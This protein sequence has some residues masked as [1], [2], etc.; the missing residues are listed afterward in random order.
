MRAPF[1]VFIGD[2]HNRLDLLKRALAMVP[3][4]ALLAF[5]GDLVDMRHPRLARASIVD[6]QDVL[7]VH[8]ALIE[9]LNSIDTS[10]FFVLGNHD[11]LALTERLGSQWICLDLAMQELPGTDF[12]LGGIG[13]SHMIPPG[14]PKDTVRRFIEG[15]IPGAP[16]GAYK[17]RG[18]VEYPVNV[19]GEPCT[20]LSRIPGE[21]STYKGNPP[22]LLLTHTPPILPIVDVFSKETLQ[23]KSL[24][25]AHAI[26]LVKPSYVVSGHLHEPRPLFHE[27]VCDSGFRAAC[28][29]TGEINPAIPLWAME[30]VDRSSIPEPRRLIW[31]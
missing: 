25:L 30:F 1:L 15:L 21:L 12:T 10:C 23:F 6:P 17:D 29:Q 4:G 31:K 20:V 11:P 13:G 5:V 16:T 22:A 19:G 3:K 8:A 24:G 14:L 2:V 7:D 9:F 27:M 26:E 28:I 18:F